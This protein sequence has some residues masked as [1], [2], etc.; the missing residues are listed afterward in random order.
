MPR[1][2]EE[3]IQQVLAATDIVDLVGRYVKLRRM[4]SLF[5]GLCPF[6]TE[7]TPSFTVSQSRGTYHCFGCGA[8]GSAIRFVMEHDGMSFVEAVKRLGDAAGI[9]IEE[10]V[11]DA[12]AEAAAKTRAL[13]LRVH[14][15]IASWYHALLMKHRMADE[16]RQYLKSRGMTAEVA[17]SW[18]LGYAPPSG[19]MLREWAAGKGYAEGVLIDAGILGAGDPDSGRPGTYPRFRHRLMF[20][21]R[22]DQ[23]EVIAFTARI[24]RADQHPAKYVNSPE[25]ML[26]TKSKVL[27]G[28]DRSKRAIAKA[29]QA[30]I[31]EGQIDMMTV[32]DSGIENVVASQ[33]TAFT[34]FHA[35]M[36][37]RHADEVVLCFDADNA[38]INA[39][40]KAFHTLAPTGLI[41]KC[42]ALPKGDDPDSLIRT[43]GPGAF[44]EIIKSAR[45]FID[46][47]VEHAATRR[48]LNEM[49]ERVRFADEMAA[50]IRLLDSPVARE[51]AIQR[52]AVR[53][54]LPEETYRRQVLR[55]F[56][57]QA[58][59][60]SATTTPTMKT[61]DGRQLLVSQDKTALLL[62]R[63]A[64][65]NAEVLHWLRQT[66]R[67]DILDDLPGASM[68]A[69]LWR[70]QC[71]PADPTSTSV[72]LAS[73]EPAEE[74]AFAGLL[75]QPAPPGGIEEA[76]HA[77]DAL[78]T[79]RLH[80]LIQRA[81]TQLKQPGLTPEED[82]SLHQRIIA[83]RKEYLDRR[84]RDP[85]TR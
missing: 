64:F 17:K 56:N 26:F 35:R 83:W 66:R 73:L 45:E 8:G 50:S 27:F 62:C 1:I 13:L 46:F 48:N 21:I 33:G 9:R 4:G 47:Q 16:A 51:T 38:G 84:K 69:L 23:G 79:A 24:L 55:D 3:T 31:V 37:K 59:K 52:V 70:S 11:W 80:A 75:A 67:E 76:G 28:F 22:N 25:T 39:A 41:V 29:G 15:D 5:K 54:G 42:V 7:R 19:E 18:K 2:P 57:P 68:L 77:L 12:N 30:V 85:D 49:R 43:Q 14:Q 34:E 71:D 74:S 32:F 53:L 40:G 58:Q 65:S 81:Q 20:P 44:A 36:L 63:L 10:E 82:A 72:F 61:S 60:A 78:E 6:H